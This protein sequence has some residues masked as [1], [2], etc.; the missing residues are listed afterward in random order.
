MA[1]PYDL[2]IRYL[3]TRGVDDLEALSPELSKFSLRPASQRDLDRQLD[4]LQEILPKGILSQIKRKLYG[5][6]FEKY[7]TILEVKDLWEAF[8]VKASRRA[9][10]DIHEDPALRLTIN[11]LLAKSLKIEEISRVVN[12]KFTAALKETHVDLYMRFFFDPRRMRRSDWKSY[13]ADAPAKERHVMFMALTES[14]DTLKTELDLPAQISVS[15]TLQWLI[16]KSFARA[17]LCLNSGTPESSQEA[18][19]WIDKIVQLSDKYEKYR[20][21]DQQDF[22]KSLQMEFDFIDDEFDSPDGE[23]LSEIE[24]TK[25]RELEGKG[26]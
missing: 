19:S 12:T 13:L 8:S 18:R 4:I 20:S 3:T 25:S 7:L 14:V 22:A 21:A 1:I 6:D 5:P 9:I 10:E 16:T 24:S 15:D 11:A 2:Y 23:M 26:K 17:K